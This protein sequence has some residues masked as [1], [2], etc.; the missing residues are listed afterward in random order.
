MGKGW[1]LFFLFWPVAA[2]ASCAMA[3]FVNWSFPYDNA[4]AASNLGI[5]ID[6]LFYLILIITAIV[7]IGTQAVLVYAL[8]RSVNNREKRAMHIHGNHK[9][10]LI[11]SII[12]GVILLFLSIYQMNIWADFRIKKYF[13]EAAVKA[14]LAEVTA[15]QFEWRFRYPAI[16]KKLQQKPQSDDLYSVNELHVPFGKPVL[17]QLRSEDVQHSFFLPALR[18]KQD[19]LPGLQIPVWFEA[20]KTGIYDL[21]CAELCGWGHYKMKAHVIVESDGEYQKYL[22]DLTQKQSYDGLGKIASKDSSRE[23]EAAEK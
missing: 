2:V 20:N 4:Q 10:E 13:P 17:I 12:P 9:L 11:W 16:G 15:R 23:S 7:F 6:G 19:A 8:W 3:P 5:R 21:V 14:P 18:V 1:C 22:K